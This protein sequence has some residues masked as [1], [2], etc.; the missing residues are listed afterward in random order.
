MTFTCPVCGFPDL[1]ESPRSERTGGGSYEICPSC[2]FEF[3]VTDDDRG[4]TYVEWRTQWVVKGM[5][6]HSAVS[7]APA[8]WNPIDQLATVTHE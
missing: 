3:G 1:T 8:G 4:F 6:W 5:P 2:G 7:R